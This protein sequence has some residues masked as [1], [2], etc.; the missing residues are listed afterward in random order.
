M[1][2]LGL[3]ATLAVA[4]TALPPAVATE[5]HAPATVTRITVGTEAEGR[6]N[7]LLGGVSWNTGSLEGVAPLAPPTVRIDASL[8]AIS[9]GPDALDLTP[10]VEKVDAVR[11]VGATPV[12]ILSYMPPWLADHR[13]AFDPRDPTRVG[14]VDLDAWEGVITEVVGGLAAASP[15][16][17]R[18]EVWNEPDVPLFWQDSLDAFLEMALSTHRAVD[19]ADPHAEVGGPAAAFPDPAFIV[20]YV[21]AVRARHLPLDFVSWHYYGNYPFFGDDGAEFD[22]PV[23]GWSEVIFPPVARENPATSPAVYRL[24]TEAVRSWVGPGPE[25]VIDEWNL[26]AAGFDDRHDTH[27]GAAF[28]LATLI[29]M[30]RAGLGSA[31]FYRAAN[32]PGDHVGDWGLV[33]TDG[34]V[35]PT[36][37]VLHAWKQAVGRRLAVTGDAGPDLWARATRKGTNVDV[38]V[39]SFEASGSGVDRTVVADAREHECGR[40]ADVRLLATPDGDLA[41]ARSVPVVD[42]RVSFELPSPAVARVTFRGCS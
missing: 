4:L 16:P 28:A 36:W 5:A 19:A 13:G 7:R 41:G 30:E 37:W 10:L 18:Y 17:V 29:E 23:P 1:R 15:G 40:R 24:Q 9:H 22:I 34:T 38:L 6:A 25:L 14:P 20:P 11:A 27:E 12:V 31:D 35:K 42:G 2:V 33:R 26:S 39:S 21:T 32:A 3:A 8:Q